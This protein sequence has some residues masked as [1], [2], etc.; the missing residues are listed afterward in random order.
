MSASTPAPK[1]DRVKGSKKNKPGSASGSGKITFSARTETSLKNKVKEHNEKAPKGRKATLSMLKAVYRRG[2]GAYS[3][4]HR[5]GKTRDQWAMARVNAYLKL[6]KSGKPSNSAY[7]QDN[8][9]LPATHPKSTKKSNS[10]ITASALVPEEQDL[11]DAILSV[12]EKHGKFDEDG[13]GVWAGYTPADENEDA[14]IGVICSNCVFYQGGDQCAI[15]SLPV[16]PNGKC[17]LAVLPDNAVRPENETEELALEVADFLAENELKL[18]ALEENTFSTTQEA[19]VALTELSGLGYES[20]FAI[21]AAWLR[22]LSTG[23]NPYNRARNLAIKTYQSNDADLLPV[24]EE[25]AN[26]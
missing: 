5:P 18:D 13:E 12:V 16:E 20:E 14:D 1:K 25:S 26:L 2:A 23:E 15:I 19:I 4:S 21:K 24:R 17:R 6:L 10:A 22:A 3:T 7:K 9:L 11:A 8:D